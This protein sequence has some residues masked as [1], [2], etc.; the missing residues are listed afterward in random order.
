MKIAHLTTIDM[1]LR[2]LLLP[3]LEAAREMGEAIGISAAG[4]SVPDLEA[5]GIRHITLT[6]STCGMKLWA[7]L[8]AIRAVLEDSAKE[9]LDILHP[10]SRDWC[11][12]ANRG[13]VCRGPD[14]GQHYS[15]ALCHPESSFLKRAIV[16]TLEWVASRF[17]DAELI[18]SPEDFELLWQRKI[19]PRSKLRR[20]AT[21]S[22]SKRFRP[23]PELRGEV[24][25]A[26][27]W[28]M[29]RSQWGWLLGSSRRRACPTLSRAARRLDNR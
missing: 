7:D 18:E 23:D 17:S 21:A 15:W 26:A 4:E 13:Q 11:L 16:Y 5:R 27:A 25:K 20:W 24:R 22:I 28:R 14:R 9:R 8:R 10:Q 2:Y 12:W 6:S 29:G 3:Q 1:S 19:M